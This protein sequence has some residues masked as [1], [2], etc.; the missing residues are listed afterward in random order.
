MKITHSGDF[1]IELDSQ[2]F[3]D[4]AEVK[5]EGGYKMPGAIV[6]MNTGFAFFAV[7][8]MNRDYSPT[9]MMVF[10]NEEYFTDWLNDNPGTEILFHL[11]DNPPICP[12]KNDTLSS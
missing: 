1:R 10:K 2:S 9:Q 7:V 11:R 12:P 4:V 5:Y 8:K 6:R 3:F